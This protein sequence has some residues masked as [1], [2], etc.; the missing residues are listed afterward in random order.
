M[1][2]DLQILD[3]VLVPL[4]Q[5]AQDS[6]NLLSELAELEKYI[7]ESYSSRSF[8]ELLQNA[9]DAGSQRLLIKRVKQHIIV[10]NDGRKFNA[11]DFE[12]LFRSAASNKE[13]E[14]S[15][16]FRG[17]GFKS[18]VG[19]AKHIHIISGDLEATFCR[20]LTSQLIPEAVSVPL[21]RIP[22][23]I[24]CDLKALLQEEIDEIL[25]NNFTTI[26][27]FSDLIADFVE[28]EFESLDPACLLFLRN[29]NQI[30]L[31]P[32]KIIYTAARKIID[33]KSVS[34]ILSFAAEKQLW[35]ICSH[36]EICIAFQKKGRKYI[37]PNLID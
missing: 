13:R 31:E 12:S 22:H 19:F 33:K 3:T 32:S 27:I 1:V 11:Q 36:N 10:A 23:P 7:A 2:K 15:I 30:V 37:T 21:I 26:F 29:V 28:S 5:E 24:D 18:V 25:D 9:D 34:V 8:I 14:T 35:L 4:L 6:P 16:G 20:E 17:I